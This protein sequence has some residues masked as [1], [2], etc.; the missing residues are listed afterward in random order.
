MTWLS[1]SSA[2]R[3]P[4]VATVISCSPR[5]TPRVGRPTAGPRQELSSSR[6]RRVHPEIDTA[7]ED[8]RVKRMEIVRAGRQDD[9]GAARGPDPVDHS[10]AAP[11]TRWSPKCLR[12][13]R[14]SPAMPTT[15]LTASPA[16]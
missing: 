5:H 4:P 11:A 15:G 1:P 12:T 7:G 13:T 6:S 3:A 10:R 8:E 14:S 9:R 2:T 16:R